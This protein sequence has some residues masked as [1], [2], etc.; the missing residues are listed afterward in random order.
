VHDKIAAIT[1]IPPELSFGIDAFGSL[2][3]MEL[4]ATAPGDSTSS[5]HHSHRPCCPGFFI[6]NMF[7][8]AFDHSKRAKLNRA[9]RI[10]TKKLLVGSHL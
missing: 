7:F 8:L 4:S 2:R 3:C 6:N 5:Q 1:Q 9:A 10:S